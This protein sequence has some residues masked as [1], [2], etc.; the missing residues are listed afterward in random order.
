ML[1]FLRPPLFLAS[2]AHLS[3]TSSSLNMPLTPHAATSPLSSPTYLPLYSPSLLAPSFPLPLYFPPLPSPQPPGPPCYHSPLLPAL[4]VPSFPPFHPMPIPSVP[5]LHT[6]TLLPLLSIPPYR[7]FCFS[8]VIIPLLPPHVGADFPPQRSLTAL[9]S[10]RVGRFTFSSFLCNRH[11]V[12][13]WGRWVFFF[14][15]P[16]VSLP[17]SL[18]VHLTLFLGVSSFASSPPLPL[19]RRSPSSV[20]KLVLSFP[21]FHRSETSPPPNFLLPPPVSSYCISNSTS[22]FSCI[23]AAAFSKPGLSLLFFLLPPN[24][25]PPSRC[26]RFVC[27]L[28]C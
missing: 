24:C 3:P 28:A 9:S 11:I 8:S 21:L 1:F 23:S 12:F 15:R 6:S 5:P 14:F 17:L 19:A 22:V 10:L 26:R 27:A 18:L 16:D 20:T 13:W 2:L 7:F 4:I 25:P